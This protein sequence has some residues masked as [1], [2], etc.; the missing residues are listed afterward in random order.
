[1]R[2]HVFAYAK[3][4][5]QI[6]CVG[7]ADHAPLFFHTI[8]ILKS[9]YFLNPKLQVSSNLFYCGLTAQFLSGLV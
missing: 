1:M 3:T 7:A 8:Y 4:K 9:L 2:K 6:S 5:A